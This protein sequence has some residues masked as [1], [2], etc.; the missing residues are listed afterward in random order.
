[1]IRRFVQSL[2]VIFMSFA[3]FRHFEGR[4]GVAVFDTY[5]REVLF[6][7][8]AVTAAWFFAVTQS[9][10]PVVAIFAAIAFYVLAHLENPSAAS[11]LAALDDMTA[12][13]LTGID[14]FRQG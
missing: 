2:A 13:V 7:V 10:R 5:W 14:R 9:L 4:I 8:V 11:F 3:A 1:M 12:R 6:G